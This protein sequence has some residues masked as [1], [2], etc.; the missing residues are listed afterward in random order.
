M[1]Q[2]IV[3]TEIRKS[4]VQI[5][6]GSQFLLYGGHCAKMHIYETERGEEY[7]SGTYIVTLPQP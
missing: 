3:L 7:I 2:M 6:A 5:L 4:Q 1:A